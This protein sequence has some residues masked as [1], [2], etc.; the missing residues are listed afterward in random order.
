VHPGGSGSHCHSFAA[1][2]E[3]KIIAVKHLILFET[4][5]EI[6]KWLVSIE[7]YLPNAVKEAKGTLNWITSVLDSRKESLPLTL[8]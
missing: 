7:P 6:T 4:L 5:E 8:T 2:K 3:G 1:T